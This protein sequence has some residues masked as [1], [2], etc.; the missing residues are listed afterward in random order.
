MLC[1]LYVFTCVILTT[2]CNYSSFFIP[3]TAR[4]FPG[5]FGDFFGDKPI[6]IKQKNKFKT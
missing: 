6:E 4:F 1:V 2:I 3:C 5:D